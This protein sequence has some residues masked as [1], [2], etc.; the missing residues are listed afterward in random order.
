MTSIKARIYDPIQNIWSVAT[1]I[2]LV[3]VKSGILAKIN[4]SN[5]NVFRPWNQQYW[6]T[7]ITASHRF[8]LET[9]G[10]TNDEIDTFM[11][12]RAKSN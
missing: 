1:I 10:M 4:G 6:L 3:T 2:N 5:Y 11:T 7:N 8:N 9:E 12:N